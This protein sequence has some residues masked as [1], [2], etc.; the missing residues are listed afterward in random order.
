MSQ[1]RGERGSFTPSVTDDDVL[2]ALRDRPDPV[3]TTSELAEFLGV[4]PETVRR[5][6]TTLC[7]RGRVE[8]KTVGAR[9]VVW[10][11]PDADAT[12]ERAPAA[13]LRGLVGLLDEDEAREARRRSDAWGEEFDRS[14]APN[15]E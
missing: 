1:D 2:A 14:L 9:A 12:V 3:S 6:L 7:E 8:R 4:T 11:V 5:H 15:G 13:P 10:W